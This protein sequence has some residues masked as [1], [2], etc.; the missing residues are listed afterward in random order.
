MPK[1]ERFGSVASTNDIAAERA[2]GGADEWTV[3]LASSQTCGRGRMGRNFV[4]EEGCGL[5]MSVVLRPK[6]SAE[7]ALLIT[8]AA[9]TAVP[10]AMTVWLMPTTKLSTK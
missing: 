2:L 3:I 9:A 4:S 5:Y 6:F 7:N 1:I 10:A 8:T